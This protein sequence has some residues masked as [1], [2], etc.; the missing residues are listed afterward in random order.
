MKKHASRPLVWFDRTY[1]RLNKLDDLAA[2]NSFDVRLRAGLRPAPP[3]RAIVDAVLA[4]IRAQPHAADQ[5]N[6]LQLSSA[7]I[8]KNGAKVVS[9]ASRLLPTT[10]PTLLADAS[11]SGSARSHMRATFGVALFLDELLTPR[12]RAALTDGLGRPSL[13]FEM[14]EAHVCAAAEL[15]AAN[16]LSPYAPNQTKHQTKL[17]R[18]KPTPLQVRAHGLLRA[19]GH[20]RRPQLSRA[21]RRSQGLPRRV[22]SGRRCRQSLQDRPRMVLTSPCGGGVSSVF[23][24]IVLTSPW[25]NPFSVLPTYQ[26]HQTTLSDKWCTT[27]H[28]ATLPATAH[29]SACVGL[30]GT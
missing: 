12:Q 13:A 22:R 24:R 27:P 9:L 7:D 18:T 6:C 15:F 4:A 11:R 21:A 8:S 29:P 3:L 5:F 19:R 2:S 25:G 10:A 1:H 20:A 16:M 30:S 26:H 23:S 28:P 17:D 14:V